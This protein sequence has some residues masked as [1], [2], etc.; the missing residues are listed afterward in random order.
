MK[1]GY[2]KLFIR[3]LFPIIFLSFTACSI[4]LLQTGGIKL[5][6]ILIENCDV[7]TLFSTNGKIDTIYASWSNKNI[8]LYYKIQGRSETLHRTYTSDDGFLFTSR[9]LEG[10]SSQGSVYSFKVQSEISWDDI[11]P[12]DANDLLFRISV[13]TTPNQYR[14]MVYIKGGW[15]RMGS[16]LRKEELPVHSVYVTDFYLDKNE[17]SVGDYKIFCQATNRT[18]P[19]QPSWNYETHPVVNVSWEEADIY[20]RWK[21]KRLPTEAEWEYAAR[22]GGKR[23]FYSWGKQKP[24]RRLGGNVADESVRSEKNNWI[25]WQGYYDG[26]IYTSPI[27]SFYSNEFGLND[28]TGNVWEWCSDWYAPDYYTKSVSNNPKG[29]HDG[30]HKVLRGGS[31]NMG[32]L[33]VRTTRR[34]RYRVDVTLNY[35]GFRCARDIN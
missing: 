21:G 10:L 5:S 24:R 22:S 1:T 18:M 33:D 17:V 16:K 2:C 9:T 23:Y 14:E 3:T 6:H 7:K 26:F 25:V 32:P 28:M 31:W 11:K 29:P 35:L 13:T 4:K 8:D 27:G 12:Q 19:Q 34:L 20:A 15:F 30:S